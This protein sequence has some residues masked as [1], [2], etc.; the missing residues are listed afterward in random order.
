M[1]HQSIDTNI[2]GQTKQSK[3]IHKCH[4]NK[5]IFILRIISYRQHRSESYSKLENP[6][7]EG[8]NTHG[9]LH[10][11]SQINEILPIRPSD[12]GLKYPPEEPNPAAAR[13]SNNEK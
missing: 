2:V 11:T 5:L 6:R 9:F 4:L 10:Q 8:N 13:I 7:L 3:I 12:L 1:H